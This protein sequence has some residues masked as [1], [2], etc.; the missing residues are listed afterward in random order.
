MNNK[1]DEQIELLGKIITVEEI[2]NKDDIKNMAYGKI[3]LFDKFFT[4]Y[5]IG[6]DISKDTK[7]FEGK[8][9]C[10]IKIKEKNETRIVVSDK[11]SKMPYSEIK[12]WFKNSKELDNAKFICLFEKSAGV[13]A[14]KK[15]N[16][17]IKYLIIYSKINFPGFPKGHIEYGETEEVAAKREA[18]EEVG[19]NVELKSNFR[20]S[21]S[22]TVY[23]TP[24]QKEVVFFL[25]EILE[26]DRVSIDTN[27]INKF[28][29]VTYEEAKC[30]LN[31]NLINILSDV[32]EY[33]K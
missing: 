23:D 27:E 13:I 9:I 17:E 6:G 15:V 3:R 12:G 31:E 20:K 29:F 19:I 25:A 22:Y 30:I 8:V 18:L 24:I 4:T 32:E 16:S 21:I 7:K 5:I 1:E 14:Y 26:N 10:I 28:E 2:N 11:N 33:I